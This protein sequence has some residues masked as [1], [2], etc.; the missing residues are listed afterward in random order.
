MGEKISIKILL[1]RSRARLSLTSLFATVHPSTLFLVSIRTM[2]LLRTSKVVTNITSDE[3][4]SIYIIVILGIS[5]R[6]Y[7]FSELLHQR[8]SPVLEEASWWPLN[9]RLLY[10]LYDLFKSYFVGLNLHHDHLIWLQTKLFNCHLLV[11][12]T[13]FYIT[14]KLSSLTHLRDQYLL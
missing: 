8:N 10:E 1:L 5:Y 11:V 4:S 6:I 7:F 12:S 2:I 14:L 13:S 3:N 9:G